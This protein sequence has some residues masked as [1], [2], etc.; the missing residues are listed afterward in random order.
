MRAV[1][2]HFRLP[3]MKAKL[4]WLILLGANAWPAAD[5]PLQWVTFQDSFEHAFTADVPKGWTAKGGLFRLGYSDARPMVDL[6]SPDGRINIRLGDVAIP[7][8]FVPNQFHREGEIYDLG[9]QAQLTV[10]HYRPGPEFAAAYAKAR[11]ENVCAE[12]S[13]TVRR[14][15]A[16][17]ARLCA[18]GHC[19]AKI[20]R[21][22]RRLFV[23]FR[24][25]RQGGL[26]VCQDLTLSRLLDGS[27]ARKL[28]GARRSSFTRA[29]N[30]PALF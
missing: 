15:R 1:A 21:W 25:R 20:V 30:S 26:C 13:S 24:P 11:F 10:A 23:R 12:L 5:M 18:R 7:V 17:N 16:T 4:V 3:G 14:R 22:P 29:C 8:Y 9:A 6:T 28:L 2:S 19:A 27:Y